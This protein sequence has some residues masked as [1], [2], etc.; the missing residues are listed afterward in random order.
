MKSNYIIFNKEFELIKTMR[1]KIRRINFYL[2]ILNSQEFYA[3]DAD[4]NGLV[5]AN[6]IRSSSSLL[7]R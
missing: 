2:K 4:A 5:G 7:T 3:A 1:Y 6:C